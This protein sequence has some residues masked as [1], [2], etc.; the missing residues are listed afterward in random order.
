MAPQ[1][2]QSRHTGLGV[3][4]ISKADSTLSSMSLQHISRFVRLKPGGIGTNSTGGTPHPHA[5][6]ADQQE[7]PGR[8]STTTK[9]HD[10]VT[11]QKPLTPP[12]RNNNHLM[13]PCPH[14]SFAPQ[15]TR[16][17]NPNDPCGAHLGWWVTGLT[18]VQSK[19]VHGCFDP[20][21]PR[22]V[23]TQSLNGTRPCTC[24]RR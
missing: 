21:G 20:L 2:S 24:V 11:K 1:A 14:L 9:I 7:E 4:L 3:D 22:L 17:Q 12:K 23:Q 18:L 19:G 8:N 13:N 6:S 5:P 10:K 16:I 15:C